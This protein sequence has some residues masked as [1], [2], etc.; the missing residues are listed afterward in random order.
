MQ[1]KAE[2]ENGMG[3][4]GR[5]IVVGKLGKVIVVPDKRSW[6]KNTKKYQMKEG[7]KSEC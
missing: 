2:E 6:S 7:S 5:Q 1:M 4:E 3:R